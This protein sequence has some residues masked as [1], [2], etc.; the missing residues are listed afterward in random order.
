MPHTYEP[1]LSL[2]Y[3]HGSTLS[4]THGL[5]ACLQGLCV[6]VHTEILQLSE[7]KASAVQNLT[8]KLVFYHPK[9]Y[10]CKAAERIHTRKSFLVTI[11]LFTVRLLLPLTLQHY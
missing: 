2:A 10:N 6:L 1:G 9:A 11:N 8:F 7:K 4:H 3:V 5:A